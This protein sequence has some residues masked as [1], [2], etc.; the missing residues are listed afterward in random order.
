MRRILLVLAIFCI[1]NAL[2]AQEKKRVVEEI[3]TRVNNEIITLSD[4]ERAQASVEDEARQDCAA[5]TPA[6]LQAA[7]KEKQ[8]NLLRDLINES[9]L[10]QKGKD[11]NINVESD[12]VKRLDQIRQQYNWKDMEE[13][14]SKLREQGVSLEDYKNNLRNGFLRQEV[15]RK[16]VGSRIQISHD[17]IRKYYEEHKQEF[18]R[19]EQVVVSE[20]FLSTEK[21][22]ESAIPQIEAKTKAYLDRIRKG[23]S[24]EELSKRY[25]EGST[26][27]EGG[28]LGAFQR[29]QLS[30][31]IEDTVFGL[32]RN[33]TTDVIRTKTG[34]LILRLDQHYDAGVQPLEKVE[35]EISGH[36][37]YERMQ[38]ELHKYLAVLREE[39]YLIVKPGY[40]DTA[41]VASTPIVEVEP[42][43]ETAKSDKKG[44]KDKKSKAGNSAGDAG[45]KSGQ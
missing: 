44:K 22:P 34:F 12:V 24:F 26:A 19:P 7:V 14:E 29:G 38:P 13:M 2:A 4:Y 20:F 27:K 3:I 28:Y 42:A 9:L 16:A 35:Q 8:A 30:K 33:E 32:K 17:D 41:A 37:Y 39:S 21:K 15:I 18:S 10:A 31:E 45:K 1:S 23:E 25:S 40:T 36:L 6:Q 5:C 43:A 11:L